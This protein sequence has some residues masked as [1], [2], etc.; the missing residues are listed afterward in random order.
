MLQFTT[1]SC[2]VAVCK[3]PASMIPTTGDEGG[4]SL[5]FAINV[6]SD[7][8]TTTRVFSSDD[9]T[10]LFLY[11]THIPERTT[12]LIGGG[13]PIIR[14]YH[15]KSKARENC[16]VVSPLFVSNSVVLILSVPP[17]IRR[18]WGVFHVL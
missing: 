16:D 9:Y 15:L 7:D 3:G 18:P 2:P 13:F 4:K 17:M 10:F 1:Y 12:I 5:I 8:P 14:N 11:G 6:V